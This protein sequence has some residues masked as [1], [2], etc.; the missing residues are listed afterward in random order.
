M[1]RDVSN[2]AEFEKIGGDQ[3]VAIR[4]NQEYIEPRVRRFLDLRDAIDR[5]N[6]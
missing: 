4:F 2:N 5:G 1:R 3:P 6:S